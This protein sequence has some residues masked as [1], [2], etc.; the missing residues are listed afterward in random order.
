MIRKLALLPAAFLFLSAL[1]SGQPLCTVSFTSSA[2]TEPTVNTID[3]IGGGGTFTEDPNNLCGAWTVSSDSTWVTFPN[4]S[5]GVTGASAI[6]YTV[7]ANTGAPRTAIL[8]VNWAAAPGGAESAQ[9]T[10]NQL[11]G[12][13]YAYNEVGLYPATGSPLSLPYRIDLSYSAGGCSVPS[14]NPLSCTTSSSGPYQLPLAP[15]TYTIT[16]NQVSNP[17]PTSGPGLLPYVFVGNAQTTVVSQQL[18]M[19][20]GDTLQVK[21][22]APDYLYLFAVSEADGSDTSGY[23]PNDFEDVTITG[24]VLSCSDATGPTQVNVNYATTCSGSGGVPPFTL[25]PALTPAIPGLT[26][27]VNANTTATVSGTPTNAAVGNYFLLVSASDSDTPA[28]TTA[29]LFP[30]TIPPP[31]TYIQIGCSPS[32]GP[33][34]PGLPYTAVCTASGGT[35]PYVWTAPGLPAGLTLTSN[36]ATAT[37]TGALPDTSPND[38]SYSYTVAVADSTPTTPET[39]QYPFS[40]SI[41]AQDGGATIGCSPNTGP[42]EVGVLFTALCS[43]SGANTVPPYSIDLAFSSSFPPGINRIPISATTIVLSGVPTSTG[44]YSYSLGATDGNDSSTGFIS[45]QGNIAP[46]VTINCN[47]GAGP[48][49]A[50]APYFNTCQSANGIPFSRPDESTYYIYWISA[51][52]LPAGLTLNPTTGAISGAAASAGAYSFTVQVYDAAHGT[53]AAPVA[54]SGTIAAALSL[55]CT[56]AAGP[57]EVGI[58]YMDTCTAANGLPPYSIFIGNSASTPPGTTFVTSPGTNPTRAVISGTPTTAAGGQPYDYVVEVFDNNGDGVGQTFTGNVA[59]ALAASCTVNTISVPV[60]GSFTTTCT[61]SNGVPHYTWTVA[62]LPAGLVTT[63]STSPINGATLT[64]SGSPTQAVPNVNISATVTDGATA[65]VAKAITGVIAPVPAITSIAPTAALAG[66]TVS[67]TVTGTGFDDSTVVTFNGTPV[68]ATGLTATGFVIQVPAN[69]IPL[70]GSYPLVASTTRGGASAAAAFPVLPQFTSITP[71]TTMAGSAAQPVTIAGIGFG[72]GATVNWNGT[73][74]STAYQSSTQLSAVIPASDF[75]AAGTAQVTVTSGGLTSGALGFIVSAGPQIT[76]LSP[77][78]AVEGSDTLTLTVNGSGFA[79]GAVVQ[80][81]G[82]ALTTN[83][84]TATQLT[85]SVPASLLTTAGS[86][87][88]TVASGAT[89]TAPAT[90]SITATAAIIGLQPTIS[91]AQTTSVGVAITT[92]APADLSGSLQLSFSPSVTGLPLNYVEQ[93]VQFSCAGAT[94]SSGNTVLDFTIPA[95][96]TSIS[97]LPGGTIQSGSVAGTITVSLVSL[98]RADT[99][100]NIT[101]VTPVTANVN[102]PA[103][104]PVVTSGTVQITNLSASGFNVELNG[105]SNTREVSSVTFTFMPAPGTQLK[106]NTSFQVPV[107]PAFASWFNS[108]DGQ[109]AGSTFGLTVPFTISGDRNVINAVTVTLTNSIGTSTPETGTITP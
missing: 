73:A 75:S 107:G 83:P 57:A 64:I 35:P 68:Q 9:Y 77:S 53:A 62:N 41:P 63:P 92:P 59:R 96:Q 86:A 7:A 8:T 94:C 27:V 80:W 102:V 71:N 69:L 10:V 46:Q 48:V 21:V 65:T 90:F 2:V 106:G 88:V 4:A 45:F 34:N 24:P 60:G 36:G 87:N 17:N 15:G 5:S 100:A 40:A 105:F 101:P 22:T 11:G 79:P 38:Q 39:A 78:S 47:S 12:V 91:S 103:M 85:A 84:G 55:T 109:A 51:G 97:P 70:A 66:T 99:Q 30:G 72:A 108:T 31:S 49:V 98:K 16:V 37:I 82:T 19:T 1:A 43:A 44:P 32:F 74:L 42:L 3:S 25:Q 89:V 81:N 13:Q 93:S 61:A 23:D 6:G 18:S 67:L 33:L 50:G 54:F 28:F 95:G 104:A 76:A 56:A 26:G 14:P 20:A 58:P 29:A 52:T